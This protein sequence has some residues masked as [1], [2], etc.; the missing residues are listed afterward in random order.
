MLPTGVPV[1][2]E[3]LDGKPV[4]MQTFG[5]MPGA[6]EGHKDTILHARIQIGGMILMGAN[7]PDA[8]PMRSAYL[9]LTLDSAAQAERIYG[10]LAEGGEVF[11]PMKE[12][13]FA[14]RF[15]MLRDRFGASW[16]LLCK[17]F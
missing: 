5:D 13:N 14:K 6:P 9:T 2:E 10:Q 17:A 16:I 15:A 11:M 7:I 3:H 4:S 12:T 1:Y 8:E